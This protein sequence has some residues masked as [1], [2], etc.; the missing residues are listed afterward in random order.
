M[1]T[2]TGPSGYTPFALSVIRDGD[3]VVLVPV[4]DLDIESVDQVEKAVARIKDAGCESIVID[5]SRTEFIDSSGLRT[6]L[7]LRD[8]AQRKGHALALTPA[9]PAVNRIFDV[10]RT[11]ELFHWRERSPR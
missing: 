10:T 7:A 3:Q 11:R 5:L 4:G 6:L 9:R 2:H 8:D 1:Q